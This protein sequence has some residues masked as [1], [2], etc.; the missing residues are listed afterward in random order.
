MESSVHERLGTLERGSLL[1]SLLQLLEH[2]LCLRMIGM[3]LQ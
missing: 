1:T 2:L 3:L